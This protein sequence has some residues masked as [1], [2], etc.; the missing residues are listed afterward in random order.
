MPLRVLTLLM[1]IAAVAGC[2][3]S[4]QRQAFAAHPAQLIER[5][6]LLGNPVQQFGGISPDGQ[7]LSWLAPREGVMNLWI[8]PAAM[9]GEARLLTQERV[10]R[11]SRYVWSPDGASLLYTKDRG[12]NQ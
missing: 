2:A 9:P 7:W 3:G 10:D 1:C 4:Q 6:Q 11:V 12:G 5:T 8:A